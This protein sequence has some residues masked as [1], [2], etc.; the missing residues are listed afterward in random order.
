[1][2]CQSISFFQIILL[3]VCIQNTYRHLW[4]SA[5][6][7]RE[8]WES[9][10]TKVKDAIPVSQVVSPYE[11]PLQENLLAH[12]ACTV[13]IFPAGVPAKIHV[14]CPAGSSAARNADSM[15]LSPLLSL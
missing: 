11:D 9:H 1:M 13:P 14:E 15:I 6:M 8:I 7:N 5:K 4:F 12:H 10:E 2:R 3:I